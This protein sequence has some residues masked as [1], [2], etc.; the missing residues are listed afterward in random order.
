MTT[1]L[2]LAEKMVELAT[3][4]PD[5]VYSSG[6]IN[7]LGYPVCLYLDPK[8]PTKGSCLVGQA[9]IACGVPPEVL[10]VDE[11][12]AAMSLIDSLCGLQ[13]LDEWDDGLVDDIDQTQRHQDDGVPWGEAIEELAHTVRLTKEL[14]ALKARGSEE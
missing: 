2:D 5:Y 14:R 3:E 8:D 7:G 1:V 6:V 11:G 4:K 13:S 9:A 10:R 12:S